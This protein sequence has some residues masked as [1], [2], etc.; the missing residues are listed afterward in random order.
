MKKF[1]IVVD[2]QKDFVDGSLGTAEAQ[3]MIPAAVEKIRKH[4]GKIFV[5]LDTHEENYLETSE[6]RHLPVVHC[7]HDT[8]GWQLNSEIEK[9]LVGHDVVTVKKGTFGNTAL[10]ALL[11][12]EAAGEEFEVELIGLCTDICVVSNALVIKSML[13]EVPLKVDAACC[14]GVS[15]ETHNAALT[16]M[17][18][19]QVEIENA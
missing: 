9:A 10:P 12:K 2:I 5:T 6:G 16:V 1:L 11:E 18:C 8:E 17:R 19:C 4:E 7:V 14:A 15:P 3:A 13:P